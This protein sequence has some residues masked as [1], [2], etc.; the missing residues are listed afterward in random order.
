MDA[1]RRQD[2]A[3]WAAARLLTLEQVE[4]IAEWEDARTAL[5]HRSPRALAAEVIG[6]VGVGI[7]AS[8]AWLAL[9]QYWADVETWAR[10]LLVV[11]ATGFAALAA[12]ATSDA[13]DDAL[14]RL[15]ALLWAAALAGTGAVAVLGAGEAADLASQN[16]L[17]VAGLVT[18]PA[19]AALLWWRRTSLQALAL[20]GAVVV[21][22]IGVVSQYDHL[23]SDVVGTTLWGVGGCWTLLALGNVVPAPRPVLFAGPLVALVGAQLM[24]DDWTAGRWLGL[25]TAAI[26]LAGSAVLRAPALAIVGLPGLF[27]FTGELVAAMTTR[28]GEPVVPRVG[29]VLALVV[30]G[31]GLLAGAVIAARH[32]QEGAR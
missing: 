22:A 14:H 10:L 16:V 7:A 21:L 30:V 25:C 15:A 26:L 29:L 24:V 3:R 19:A 13:T 18:V 12:W 31:L 5:P 23:S 32:E 9:E 4:A 8:A 11:T 28:G 20:L 6:Y 17:L 2:L 1:E 27:V